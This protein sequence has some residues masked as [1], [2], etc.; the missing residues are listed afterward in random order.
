MKDHFLSYLCLYPKENICS[1]IQINYITVTFLL[2]NVA[3]WNIIRSLTA[4]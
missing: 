3:N 4:L 1:N 2:L